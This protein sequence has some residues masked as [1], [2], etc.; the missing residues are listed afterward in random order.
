VLPVVIDDLTSDPRVRNLVV[1]QSRGV[2]GDAAAQ[3]RTGT[4]EADDRVEAA[5][6]R[7]FGGGRA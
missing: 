7:I 3:V 6:R 5:V 4:A 2:L 1:E